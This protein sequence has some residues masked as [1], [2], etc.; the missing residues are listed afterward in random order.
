M[1]QVDP[2][3]FSLW[4]VKLEAPLFDSVPKSTGSGTIRA[5]IRMCK[6]KKPS[7]ISKR[8]ANEKKKNDE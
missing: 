5:A 4:K 2:S 1:N 3:I 8:K 6:V 7:T